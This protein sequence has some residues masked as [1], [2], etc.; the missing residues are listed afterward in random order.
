[1]MEKSI[2]NLLLV[3]LL[4]EAASL[5]FSF[6][7]INRNLRESLKLV[8]NSQ[9]QLNVAKEQIGKSKETLDSMQAEMRAFGKYIEDIQQRVHILDLERRNS[10]R[11]FLRKRDSIN[12]LLD[13]LYKGRGI[14]DNL[15]E[16]KEFN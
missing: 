6:V 7:G 2:R 8:K 5:V 1:M 12:A 10:D 13:S 15:E 4:L 3:L 14:N 11:N 9:Q 16:V